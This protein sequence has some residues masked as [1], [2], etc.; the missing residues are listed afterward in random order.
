[1]IVSSVGNS[2]SPRGYF[3][4]SSEERKNTSDLSFDS[5]E[6]SFDSSEELQRSSVEN[7]FS[8]PE[9]SQIATRGIVS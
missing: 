3:L 8:P 7:I 2:K 6:V 4:F 9:E 5:S 1:L